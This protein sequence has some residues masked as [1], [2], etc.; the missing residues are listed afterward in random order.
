MYAPIFPI[1][2]AAECVLLLATPHIR[3]YKCRNRNWTNSVISVHGQIYGDYNSKLPVPFPHVV[4]V[5]C[6]QIRKNQVEH[7]NS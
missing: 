4:C 2:H 7:E 1:H 6:V 3:V 5:C